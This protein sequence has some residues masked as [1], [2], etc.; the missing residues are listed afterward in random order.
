MYDEHI[1][2]VYKMHFEM[3]DS[4]NDDSENVLKQCN[5]GLMPYNPRVHRIYVAC[6][7]RYVIVAARCQIYNGIYMQNAQTGSEAYTCFYYTQKRQNTET[8]TPTYYISVVEP[9][10]SHMFVYSRKIP[11]KHT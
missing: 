6:D 9:V 8:P 2:H 5:S 7:R 11:R 10:K 3:N 4:K 1:P